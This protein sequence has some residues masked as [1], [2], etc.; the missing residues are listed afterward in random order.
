MYSISLHIYTTWIYAEDTHIHINQ[1]HIFNIYTKIPF[2][3]TRDAYIC[4]CV[5]CMYIN[6][7]KL[8]KSFTHRIIHP[9]PNVKLTQAYTDDTWVHTYTAMLALVTFLSFQ[10][11]IL[12]ILIMFPKWLV[13]C[14][15]EWVIAMSMLIPAENTLKL[16][17]G[18]SIVGKIFTRW[19]SA[20]CRMVG[21]APMQNVAAKNEEFIAGWFLICCYC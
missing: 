1:T 17:K 13:E 3:F 6:H 8:Y 16:Q 2:A 18:C 20:F 12:Q 5:W 9:H 15:N 14:R 7:L 21:I 4:V 19:L 10:T 11:S